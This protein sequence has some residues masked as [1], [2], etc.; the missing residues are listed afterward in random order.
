MASIARKGRMAQALDRMRR[1]FPAD[2][3]FYPRTWVLPAEL[4]AFRSEF[5]AQ[6]KSSR[7]YIIKPDAGCQGK[8]IYLTQELDERIAGMEPQVRTLKVCA[9]PTMNIL[10]VLHVVCVI[11]GTAEGL[12]GLK[13]YEEC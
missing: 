3:N 6:G 7:T 4:T 13:W 11:S 10:C 1:Q 8:G 12:C 2:Y 5:D 9:L